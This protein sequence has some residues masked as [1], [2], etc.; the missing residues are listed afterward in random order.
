MGIEPT[1]VAWEATVLPLNY[2]RSS[3][4]PKS[5]MNQ[6]SDDKPAPRTVRSFVLRAGRITVAQQRA[7]E[8]LWP[9]YGLPFEPRPLDLDAVFGRRAPRVVEV[10]FGDGE[11]LCDMARRS[12]EQDFIGVEVHEPGVGHCLLLIERLGLTNVRLIRHDAVEV[13][14][15]QIPDGS[16]A[17]VNLFFPDPWPKKR[18][19]KRRI[20]QPEFMRLVASKLQP[21][22]HFRMATDWEPYAEHAAAVLAAASDFSAVPDADLARCGTKFERRGERLGH[23]VSDRVW[24][25]S[26]AA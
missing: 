26:T 21:G 13:L 16:L 23:R 9:R 18:H 19:H 20:V 15:E 17:A 12:P 24:R 4:S 3:G 22:G 14:Q 25:R 10:G 6:S 1:L 8:E 7:L 2:T 5:Y 11:L